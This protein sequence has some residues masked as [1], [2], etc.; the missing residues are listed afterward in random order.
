M[1]I[2]P[3]EDFTGVDYVD[4]DLSIFGA[5]GGKFRTDGRPPKMSNDIETGILVRYGLVDAIHGKL[6][7]TDD[8]FCSIFV[9]DFQF[10]PL[11]SSRS[12]HRVNIDLVVTSD[13]D[14]EVRL[15]TPTERVSINPRVQNI[16]WVVGGGLRAGPDNAGAEANAERT[17]NREDLRYATAFGWPSHSPLELKADGKP[18]NC[19][20]W[21]IEENQI[22]KDGVPARMRAACLVLRDDEDE[23]KLDLTFDVRADWKTRLERMWGDTPRQKP[24]IIDPKEA[25]TRRIIRDY[26]GDNL[27]LVPLEDVWQVSYGTLVGQVFATTRYIGNIPDN[28]RNFK[29]L[30]SSLLLGIQ[31]LISRLWSALARSIAVWLSSYS[32]TGSE[33]LISTSTTL[34]S[35]I[36]EI[37]GHSLDTGILQ[38]CLAFINVIMEYSD[39]SKNTFSPFAV[40]TD[41]PN[42][43]KLDFKISENHS[44]I[45]SLFGEKTKPLTSLQEHFI[46]DTPRKY[47]SLLQP[48]ILYPCQDELAD[49]VADWEKQVQVVNEW[50]QVPSNRFLHLVSSVCHPKRLL[51]HLSGGH[52]RKVYYFRFRREDP[53]LNNCTALLASLLIQASSGLSPMLTNPRAEALHKLSSYNHLSKTELFRNL[54][55]LW[56]R[57]KR[58]PSSVVV[59]I[60][61]LDDCVDSLSWLVDACAHIEKF[62]ESLP[63]FILQSTGTKSITEI[64]GFSQA[65]MTSGNV[66]GQSVYQLQGEKE[67]RSLIQSHS[68]LRPLEEVF[69]DF[70][71]RHRQDNILDVLIAEWICKHVG[72]SVALTGPADVAAT[73]NDL[74]NISTEELIMEMMAQIPSHKLR[75]AKK[76]IT[77]V[78]TAFRPI[79]TWELRDIMYPEAISSH[80]GSTLEFGA[81]LRMHL[82]GL[83]HVEFNELCCAHSTVNRYLKRQESKLQP[84]YGADEECH[85]EIIQDI[86]AYLAR[87]E[88]SPQSDL[89]FRQ[90]L[91]SYAVKFLLPHYLKLKSLNPSSAALLSKR[92]RGYFMNFSIGQ[93]LKPCQVSELEPSEG[94]IG[95][96]QDEKDLSL[97]NATVTFL[98]RNGGKA[99]TVDDLDELCPHWSENNETVEAAMI[100]SILCGD[101]A[102]LK[103]LSMPPTQD[104]NCIAELGSLLLCD[105]PEIIRILFEKANEVQKIPD[106]LLRQAGSLGIDEIIH[107]VVEKVISNDAV[108][109]LPDGLFFD[110]IVSGK[111]NIVESLIPAILKANPALHF[112]CAE[113]AFQE[114]EP[115]ILDLLYHRDVDY[116]SE[117]GIDKSKKFLVAACGRG[118][119]RAVEMI[120]IT[121]DQDSQGW[122]IGLETAVK[123]GFVKCIK[124]LFCI[125]SPKTCPESDQQLLW[126][127]LMEGIGEGL[128]ESVREMLEGGVDPNHAERW[129]GT[130][131]LSLAVKAES[132]AMVQLL[133]KYN[134]PLEVE[135]ELGRTPL[136][137][138]S[139][140][141]LIH[142]IR[143][144][145]DEGARIDARAQLG[146]TALYLACYRN[147]PDIVELLLAEG[148]SVRISTHE[149][150]WSPLEAAYD[151]PEVLK[152]LV[153]KDVDYRRVT[154][155]A[156]ALW[157][158]ARDGET[159][160]L[161]ILLSSKEC[162]LEFCA[163]NRDDDEDGWTALAMAVKEGHTE[164]ARLLL[165]AGSDVDH[166]NPVSGGFI[167]QLSK[168]QE[169][170]ALLLEY[171]PRTSLTDKFGDTALHSIASD[172]SIPIMKRLINFKFDVN[173]SNVRGNTPLH[174]ACLNSNLEAVKLLI[175]H[176]ASIDTVNSLYSSPLVY[177][178]MT[179]KQQLEKIEYL[180]EGAGSGR[181]ILQG[182]L[183]VTILGTAALRSNV[184]TVKYLCE[185]GGKEIL[186]GVD[187]FGCT[188]LFEACYREDG[189]LDMV[190]YLMEQ[191]AK[192]SSHKDVM[193]RTLLHC[194]ATTHNT[195]L[196]KKLI[197]ADSKLLDEKDADGW[198]PLHWATRQADRPQLNSEDWY[199]G[200]V[201]EAQVAETIALLV[202]GKQERYRDNHR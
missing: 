197:H 32:Y 62:S 125:I 116:P 199:D 4:V 40:T 49:P 132:V 153:H 184:E 174:L 135:D 42:E 143:I 146:D 185:H 122:R 144:L 120:Q 59:V 88:G 192:V 27:S 31:V 2:E 155:G 69:Y 170:V 202:D 97:L 65:I 33:G 89:L 158:A 166:V 12:I 21:L 104:M 177:A 16:Q 76:I 193:G 138:A 53:S 61:N 98:I 9:F 173:A 156:T 189:A 41:L 87:A 108:H 64:L 78:T 70:L 66:G 160:S 60:W 194:A 154:E 165:E 47:H 13:A 163:I 175:R 190:Q 136:F 109:E 111:K 22:S 164:A 110:A 106:I 90:E 82:S 24:L 149:G 92:V 99:L 5:G 1:E 124:E 10:N 183:G 127:V 118:N 8:K 115:D 181:Y 188:A 80:Q 180:I 195:E 85:L 3:S 55:D 38:G 200:D 131:V 128:V 168:T 14:T 48:P 19:A 142:I 191:G 73:L 58:H 25:S 117:N 34:A 7:K 29:P 68:L 81:E 43:W 100:E 121:G 186:N 167:L 54:R 119:W 148:A 105:D 139:S 79:T 94:G 77:W 86:L 67:V 75:W 63:L 150:N 39:L 112:Q 141:N 56:A 147:Y 198:G 113:L 137:L 169:I 107:P 95:E 26:V 103:A 23:F 129:N 176:D 74:T 187:H 57:H 83:I 130:P 18:S 133:R 159:E 91:K 17:N 46:L 102:L 101:T 126:E 84:W 52:Q 157:R 151:Y 15:V 123:R 179:E 162:D 35:T 37:N 6:T 72:S 161:E 182:K 71:K 44:F 96:T 196:I 152:L 11:K 134:V 28:I 30:L 178:C 93:T 36:L 172:Q 201:V 51:S 145:L 140:L 45:H 114:G 50:S 171:S 20:K